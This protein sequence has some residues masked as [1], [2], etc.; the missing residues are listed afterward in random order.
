ME[1]VQAAR[2]PMHLWIVGLA[3]ATGDVA[4]E[5]AAALAFVQTAEML[6][7]G[8]RVSRFVHSKGHASLYSGLQS[9]RHEYGPTLSAESRTFERP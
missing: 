9:A 2:T 4:M 7:H 1:D 6:V 5:A 8:V 3:T